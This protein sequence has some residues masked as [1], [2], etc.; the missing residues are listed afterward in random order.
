[1][2]TRRTKIPVRTLER[3]GRGLYSALTEAV[4]SLGDAQRREKELSA[5]EEMNRSEMEQTY[6]ALRRQR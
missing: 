5:G 2:T 4:D 6:P 1:M 3:R